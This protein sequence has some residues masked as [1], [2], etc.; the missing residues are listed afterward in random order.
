VKLRPATP[1]DVPVLLRFIRELAVFEREP[2][3]V[4][5]TEQRLPAG[6]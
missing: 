3:A 1:A 2:G 6:I 4:E 5:M